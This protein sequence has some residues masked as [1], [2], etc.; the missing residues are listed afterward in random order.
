MLLLCAIMLLKLEK[1]EASLV[2]KY[3]ADYFSHIV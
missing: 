1:Q 3:A 2:S